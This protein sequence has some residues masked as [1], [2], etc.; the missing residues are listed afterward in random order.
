MKAYEKHERREGKP[1]K[2]ETALQLLAAFAVRSSC[3]PLTLGRRSRPIL[4]GERLGNVR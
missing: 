3:I 1:V 2:H 4:R